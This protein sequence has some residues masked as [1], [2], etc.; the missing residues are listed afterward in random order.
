MLIC[1]YCGKELEDEEGIES[2]K[3]GRTGE[4]TCKECEEE[5]E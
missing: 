1:A 5:Y 3:R 4:P 2:C